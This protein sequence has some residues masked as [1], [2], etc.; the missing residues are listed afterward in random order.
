MPRILKIEPKNEPLDL[1]NCGKLIYKNNVQYIEQFGKNAYRFIRKN[2][3]LGAILGQYEAEGTIPSKFQPNTIISV[4]TDHEHIQKLQKILKELLGLEFHIQAKRVTVCKNCGSNTIEKGKQNICPKCEKS[5]Y[6]EY[7][8]LITK[9][10]LAKTIFTEGLGIEH[11]YSYLKEIPS[12]LYNSPKECEKSFILSYFKGDGSERDYRTKGGTFDLNFETTS[13]RLVFGFN[14]LMKKLG[15]IMSINEHNPP[16]T[17]PKSKK[18]YTM[19]IRG[20]SNFEILMHHFENLPE[21]DYTTSD[22]RSSVNNQILLRKLNFELQKKYGISL[23]ELSNKGIIPKNAQHIATQLKR[24][25]NLSEVLLLK[26]L[27]GLRNEELLTPLVKKLEQ[28]FRKNT[29]TR[30]KK[31]RSSKTNNQTYKIFV[32][33]IGY[34]SGTAFIYVKSKDNK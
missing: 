15:V 18:L 28:V 6:N 20:S 33:G 27:D 4:S 32:D 30:I 17:R 22:L 8:V 16:S 14:L 1:I 10:K 19:S 11:A 9:T 12:F 13:R 3:N 23:R 31:I 2:A 25:T 21:V 26:T 5:I 29:F 7:Y 34:C 24:K